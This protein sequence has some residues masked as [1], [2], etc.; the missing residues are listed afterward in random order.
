MT[1]LKSDTPLARVLLQAIPAGNCR[2][3][4]SLLDANPGLAT[5]RIV[6]R[7][8][9]RTLLHVA[10]AW[11]GHHP[12]GAA[13]VS[14]LVTAGADVNAPFIGRHA[15]TPLHWAASSGDVEVLAALVA[16]GANIEARGGV[17]G[18][19]TPLATACAF[20][21]WSAA[22]RLVA[23][24]AQAGLVEAATLGLTDRLEE[25][26][27]AL[28]APPRDEICRAFWGACRGAQYGAAACLYA[29]GADIN[30]RPRW[31]DLTPL[32]VARESGA[33]ELA[34]WLCSLGALSASPS[35]HPV[36]SATGSR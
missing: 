17:I 14:L 13:T 11:P 20:G 19:G 28:P 10:T 4:T 35:R 2:A 32:D 33:D 22:R 16:R 23:C 6:D 7:S 5:V 34:E 3:L 27:S 15:E 29:H 24:G 26:A 31:E 21:Q 30:W 18:G 36:A 9:W 12:N 8:S 25:L 1:T